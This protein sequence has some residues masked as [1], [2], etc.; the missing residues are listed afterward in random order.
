MTQPTFPTRVLHR[1]A[2]VLLAFGSSA[3]VAHTGLDA[4]EHHGFLSG[5]LH[6]MNGL[7]HLGAMLAVGL[8]SATTTARPW[9]APLSFAFTLLGGALL[10]QAGLGLAGVELMIM[11]SLLVVGLLLAAQ[12]RL[13]V[14]AGAVLVGAFALFHGMAHGQELNGGMALLGMVMGTAVL[15]LAGLAAGLALR[16]RF[17][18]LP[19]VAGVAV[20][21]SGAVLG[22]SLLA[23]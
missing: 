13:P 12:A 10:A 23:A 6:P 20:A 5:L 8:W 17:I 19:R 7:D 16:Q 22:W 1:V 18:W 4:A 15:H 14:G 3:A 21:A 9:A 11:A 2:P